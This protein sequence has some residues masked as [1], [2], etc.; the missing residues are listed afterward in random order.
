[1][2][3]E[4]FCCSVVNYVYQMK[5]HLIPLM[6]FSIEYQLKSIHFTLQR[7]A[8]ESKMYTPRLN[9][10]QTINQLFFNGLTFEWQTAKKMHILLFL[11][12]FS[13]T[14]VRGIIINLC[15]ES[16]ANRKGNV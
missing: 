5:E 10:T 7:A 2:K 15:F 16:I 14:Y 11:L 9:N 3:R 12:Q 4:F 13:T 8:D 1:M 6:Q